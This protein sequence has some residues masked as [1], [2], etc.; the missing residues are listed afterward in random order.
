M[1]VY[2]K[3][4]ILKLECNSLNVI[5][6]IIENSGGHLKKILFRPQD[7]IDSDDPD[8][9]NGNSFNFIRTTYKNC[10]LI[11]YLTIAFSPS[12]KHFA[13]FEKLLKICQNLKSLLLVI[14]SGNKRKTDEKRMGYGKKLLKILIESA[15]D[16]FKEI[17]FYYD[18]KFSLENLEE[19]LEKW[20]GRSAL[21]IFTSDSIYGR[22]DY[23]KLINKYKIEGVIKDFEH[24]LY[25]DQINYHYEL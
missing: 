9:F 5:S 2:H 20:R 6:S 21:S 7:T 10:P 19:F 17:R 25:E 4:E 11:E 12:K 24:S 16:N 15:P 13:K 18:F 23:K 14:H 1:Q 22:E 3:L 8:D